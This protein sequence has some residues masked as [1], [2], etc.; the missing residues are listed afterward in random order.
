LTRN[1]GHRALHL[2]PIQTENP[3]CIAISCSLPISSHSIDSFSF[4]SPSAAAPGS[5]LAAAH[6]TDSFPAPTH[7]LTCLAGVQ[8]DTAPARPRRTKHQPLQPRRS[9]AG[10]GASKV[11]VNGGPRRPR[12]HPT[13]ASRRALSQPSAGFGYRASYLATARSDE[14]GLADAT[15]YQAKSQGSISFLHLYVSKFPVHS[16]I[17]FCS[18]FDYEKM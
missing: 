18:S 10:T 4:S 2:L 5:P 16:V 8:D 15:L 6:P 3:I 14:C 12:A 13:L 9:S 7:R 11:A 1:L 17:F